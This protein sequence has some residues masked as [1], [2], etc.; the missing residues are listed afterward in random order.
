[1]THFLAPAYSF[2]TSRADKPWLTQPMGGGALTTFTW[3]TGFE[4]ARRM[5]AYLKSLDLPAGSN[6]ALLSKNSAWWILADLAIWMAGHVSV[7]VYPTL[8]ATSVRQILEH[9]GA[10]LLFVGKLDGWPAMKP[11]VPEGLPMIGM[12]LCPDASLPKWSDIVVRHEPLSGATERKDDELATIVYTSGSTG[13]PKGVML[14][15]GNLKSAMDSARDVFQFSAEDRL[16]SYLPLAHVMERALIGCG[17][18]SYGTQVFFAEALDTFLADLN[19]ARPTIFVSV[20]RLWLKF[21]AGV[22]AKMPQKKLNLLL[23]IPV[24]GGIVKEKILTGLGLDSVRFAFS[25]S[26]P[27]PAEVLAWYRQLGLELLEAY[28]MSENFCISHITKPGRVRAGYVGEPWP[29]VQARLTPEGELVM[30]CGALMKG[31]YNAP[32]IT[33]QVFT[34]DGFLK[35]GDRGEIDA[36]GRLKITGRVKEQFKTTS[37]KY[38]AP[39]PIENALLVNEYLESGCV[40]GAGHPQPCAVVTVAEAYRPQIGDAGLRARIQESVSRTLKELN[41]RLDPHEAVKVVVIAKEPWSIETGV[42]TPTLK[43]KRAVVEERYAPTLGDLYKSPQP[44]IWE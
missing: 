17:T 8:T 42:L 32:D 19:R 27:I 3:R 40:M 26:A 1:M 5:A 18:L 37:G 21:Q 11:G 15:F 29:G 39:A 7:P 38:V 9:S 35:T 31:Y 10:R 14:T 34:E 16:L 36:E 6:I 25:G 24:L 23:K 30:K 41:Q 43:V 2:E 13:V 4:E 28:G 12:P 20:P 22:L 33:A 44:V